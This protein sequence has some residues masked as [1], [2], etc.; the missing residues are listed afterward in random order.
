MDASLFCI[1]HA[2]PSSDCMLRISMQSFCF[3]LQGISDEEE[4]RILLRRAEFS[5]RLDCGMCQPANAFSL[6]DKNV[7]ISSI[8]MHYCIYSLKSELDEV[9]RGLQSLG[10]LDVVSKNP[11]LRSL[12][13]Y[14]PS[15]VTAEEM[16]IPEFSPI[17]RAKEE[18][19]IMWFSE[20]LHEMEGGFGF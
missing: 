11:I 12:F 17:G 1:A 10:F 9:R 3:Q 15:K 7:I 4:F 20:L 18:A 16:F 2:L 19:V 8:A 13:E 5:F 6:K 14:S